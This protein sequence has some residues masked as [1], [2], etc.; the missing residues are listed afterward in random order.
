MMLARMPGFQ[1]V[2]WRCEVRVRVRVRVRH[3]T[4]LVAR[5]AVKTWL[6]TVACS[7]MRQD[8]LPFD[9]LQCSIALQ[10]GNYAA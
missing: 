4:C 7:L 2:S 5:Q 8:C 3:V 9:H 6:G 10:C 1:G